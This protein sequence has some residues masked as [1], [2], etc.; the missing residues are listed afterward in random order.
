MRTNKDNLLETLKVINLFL[1]AQRVRGGPR[2]FLHTR[3]QQGG[4]PLSDK[5]RKEAEAAEAAKKKK[6]SLKE[7]KKKASKPAMGAADFAKSLKF[8]PAP[9]GPVKKSTRDG[10]S[11]AE[12]RGMRRV[13]R[14]ASE[15]KRK[16]APSL[17]DEPSP[18]GDKISAIQ[19]RIKKALA[20]STKKSKK[21]DERSRW[22]AGGYSNATAIM[23]AANAKADREWREKEK[24]KKA[25]GQSKPKPKTTNEAGEKYSK[26][27]SL[28][29]KAKQPRG[30]ER[31]GKN[32]LTGD[33]NKRR[34]GAFGDTLKAVRKGLKEVSTSWAATKLGNSLKKGRSKKDVAASMIK[35]DKHQDKKQG[36]DTDRRKDISYQVARTA[37]KKDK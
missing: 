11:A 27:T 4:D 6:A 23:A 14:E 20:G 1:E 18:L 28:S 37:L 10:M 29:K 22:S 26:Q 33:L 30:K 34:G 2:D 8:K 32:D 16:P 24:S 15:P 17:R 3:P 19:D 21:T 36:P 13:T 25:E 35:L 5:Q 12:E 9:G 7:E 31:T